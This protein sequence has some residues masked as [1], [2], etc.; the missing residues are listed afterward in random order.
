MP[1]QRGR[2]VQRS[3]NGVPGGDHPVHLR[4]N[5]NNVCATVQLQIDQ[6]VTLTRTAFT[7]TLTLN[8]QMS[9]DSLQDVEL[10]LIVTDADGNPVPA[11]STHLRRR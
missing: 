8:D 3:G 4:G 6:T 1:G 11:C 2:R 7:G 10:D 9:G 5:D